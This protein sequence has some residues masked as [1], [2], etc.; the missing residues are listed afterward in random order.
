M[1]C[2]GEVEWGAYVYR[3]LQATLH[4]RALKHGIHL[5]TLLALDELGNLLCKGELLSNLLWSLHGHHDLGI[6][7][8]VLDRE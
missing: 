8:A 4:T 3:S 5:S 6:R 7:E 2:E 1:K